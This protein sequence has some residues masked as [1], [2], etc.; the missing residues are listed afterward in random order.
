MIYYR[1]KKITDKNCLCFGSK[2]FKGGILFVKSSEA[3][4]KFVFDSNF[5][6][7]EQNF[8]KK[9]FY[10]TC[11]WCSGNKKKEVLQRPKDTLSLVVPSNTHKCPLK[12]FLN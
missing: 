6:A 7:H 4:K 9:T 11:L 2:T 12:K 5:R 8:P 1:F 10:R 3:P